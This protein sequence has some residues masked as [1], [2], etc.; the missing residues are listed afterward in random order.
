MGF[1]PEQ[2]SIPENFQIPV[3]S[4]GQYGGHASICIRYN[5]QAKSALYRIGDAAPG[6]NI[7]YL[8]GKFLS[9]IGFWGLVSSA[10]LICSS[11]V[12]QLESP[13]TESLKS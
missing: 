3:S 7:A 13:P 6:D 12:C 4:F 11:C 5:T 1:G 8:Q 9:L 2:L 10:L